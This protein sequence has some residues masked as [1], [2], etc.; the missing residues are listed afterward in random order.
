MHLWSLTGLQFY[1][2]SFSTLVLPPMLLGRSFGIVASLSAGGASLGS[3]L[4]THLYSRSEQPLLASVSLL[5]LIMLALGA[6]LARSRN[7][8]AAWW[9]AAPLVSATGTGPPEAAGLLE[10]PD[11]PR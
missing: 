5:F 2:R 10:K 4:G 3:L 1:L 11:R 6:V 7:E 9:E 8:P